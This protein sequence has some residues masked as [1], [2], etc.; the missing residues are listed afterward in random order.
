[1]TPE[2]VEKVDAYAIRHLA[3]HLYEAGPEMHAELYDLFISKKWYLA[4]QA[5]DP[6]NSTY[7]WGLERAILAAEESPH[8]PPDLFPLIFLRGVTETLADNLPDSAIS[9]LAHIGQNQ[10]FGQW[11]G[12]AEDE[13]EKI[14]LLC[15]MAIAEWQQGNA[16]S[17]LASLEEAGKLAVMNF[18]TDHDLSILITVAT[19]AHKIH[20]RDHYDQLLH[21]IQ[22]SVTLGETLVSS[23]VREFDLLDN[24]KFILALAQEEVTNWEELLID[25][26]EDALGIIARVAGEDGN[27]DLIREIVQTAK[28]E[29]FVPESFEDDEVNVVTELI[30]T[31]H[32]KEALQILEYW[33]IADLDSSLKLARRAGRAGDIET[34]EK[35]IL[36]TPSSE[37]AEEDDY[38]DMEDLVK[39]TILKT[40]K[41]AGRLLFGLE[42]D[43]LRVLWAG[44]EGL[45]DVHPKQIEALWE[46]IQTYNSGAGKILANALATLILP[47]ETATQNSKNKDADPGAKGNI[48][49]RK[50]DTFLSVL[51]L[52]SKWAALYFDED[53]REEIFITIAVTK[54]YFGDFDG[55]LTFLDKVEFFERS[56]LLEILSRI[57]LEKRD[58]EN[59][60]KIVDHFDDHVDAEQTMDGISSALLELPSE[61]A[62][63]YSQQ[64]FSLLNRL[65][66]DA[67]HQFNQLFRELLLA[68]SHRYS[69]SYV[70]KLIE[71]FGLE[72]GASELELYSQIALEQND[73]STA[74]HFFNIFEQLVKL[75]SPEINLKYPLQL[76]DG[77]YQ[78]DPIIACSSNMVVHWAQTAEHVTDP[79]VT[80]QWKSLAKRALRLTQERAQKLPSDEQH[81]SWPYLT[82][83]ARYLKDKNIL[84]DIWKV[85]EEHGWLKG[86]EVDQTLVHLAVGLTL[87]GEYSDYDSKYFPAVINR[88]HR[89]PYKM[90]ALVEMSQAL[91]GMPPRKVLFWEVDSRE[92]LNHDA[93]RLLKQA[94]KELRS[95]S[96]KKSKRS[97]MAEYSNHDLPFTNSIST[98]VNGLGLNRR[99]L[100]QEPV[101]DPLCT[102]IQ[103]FA[104]KGWNKEVVKIAEELAPQHEHSRVYACAV[105]ALRQAGKKKRARRLLANMP[106]ANNFSGNQE[107]L[108][109]ARIAEQQALSNPGKAWKI[110][111]TKVQP[112]LWQSAN[113]DLVLRSCTNVILQSVPGRRWECVKEMMEKLFAHK[114]AN[115]HATLAPVLLSLMDEAQFKL[116]L[117]KLNAIRRFWSP[118]SNYEYN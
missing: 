41:G 31:G 53:D 13:S 109:F 26:E 75:R 58:I 86:L 79:G 68:S 96:K 115:I 51:D 103:A 88:I 27:K 14:D 23:L 9:I 42:P 52:G 91:Q 118:K 59:A 44:F 100:D 10:P 46:R 113:L 57:A 107:A 25:S 33:Q 66:D 69:T 77:V 1:M 64:L 114:G 7:Y 19:T 85:I 61:Q 60:L 116:T 89:K 62:R 38:L 36:N 105:I 28:N 67:R 43:Q 117:K 84:H 50:S 102:V 92:D 29:R 99:P 76:I 90:Q 74:D 45:G 72:L 95:T 104:E 21:K 2:F 73:V 11:Y 12:R 49:P 15:E 30:K 80:E 47:T 24:P 63:V 93:K 8:H 97:T 55:A 70:L 5:Y 37:G 65:P 106:P 56:E 34:I 78:P 101:G 35:L 111:K 20:S 39:G 18:E 108:T 32:G 71:E 87:T 98:S 81:W 6:T 16:D 48:T 3:E 40:M 4:N 83:A 110:F 17:A 112:G 94:R 82:R 54:A 22:A